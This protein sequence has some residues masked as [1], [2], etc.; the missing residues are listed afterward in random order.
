MIT[1]IMWHTA[2]KCLLEKKLAP[3]I[4]FS[5]LSFQCCIIIA[6]MFSADLLITS[7]IYMY[8]PV[9]S[10]LFVCLL[11]VCLLCFLADE[12]EG[13]IGAYVGEDLVSTRCNGSL[14]TIFTYKC[15]SD[16]QWSSQHG[17]VSGYLLTVELVI[18]DNCLV[19]K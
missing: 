18:P 14:S 17:D 19:N 4:F 1:R 6:S 5:R 12:L 8:I 13:F 3:E 7:Y 10:S 11:F 2:A 9:L 15:D 16:A